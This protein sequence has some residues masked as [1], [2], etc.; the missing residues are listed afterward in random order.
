ARDVLAQHVMGCA[1]SEPFDPVDLDEEV[2]RAA[3]YAGLSWE[4]FEQVVDFVSTGG[5][6]L[7]NYDRFRRIIRGPDGRWRVLNE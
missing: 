6:A 2:R 4:A 3:P 1:C 5:Y 7:R